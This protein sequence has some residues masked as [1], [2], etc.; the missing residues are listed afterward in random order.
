MSC[1]AETKEDQTAKQP[2][3]LVIWYRMPVGFQFVFRNV[4]GHGDHPLNLSILD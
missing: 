1:M 4:P 3:W 2:G